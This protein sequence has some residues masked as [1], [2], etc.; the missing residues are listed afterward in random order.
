VL[1]T[2]D[3]ALAQGNY[4]SLQHWL[5]ENVYQYRRTFTPQELLVR[6][7]GS[8]LDV[9]PYL[10]YLTQEYNDLFPPR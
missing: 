6:A 2:L 8:P 7:T 3:E 9:T 5:T 1:P 10:A 4:T